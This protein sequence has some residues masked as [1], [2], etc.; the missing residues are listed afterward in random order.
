MEIDLWQITD[1]QYSML[2]NGNSALTKFLL[3]RDDSV[4]DENANGTTPL[5][6]PI[7][8]FGLTG[9]QTNLSARRKMLELGQGVEDFFNEKSLSLFLIVKNLRNH[10]H[11]FS[12]RAHK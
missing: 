2:L 7:I 8:R 6:S 12:W 5:H 4:H 11:L 9:Q 1:F 3:N 10:P